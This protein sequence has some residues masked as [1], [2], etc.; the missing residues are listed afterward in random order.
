MARKSFVQRMSEKVGEFIYTADQ[1][2]RML[3]E[4]GLVQCSAKRIRTFAERNGMLVKPEDYG[5]NGGLWDAKYW[6]RRSDIK[7]VIDG[8]GISVTEQ[9]LQASAEKLGY[10]F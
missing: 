10:P 4:S 1:I 9:D 3:T 8:M 5:L 6:I 2:D 7:R